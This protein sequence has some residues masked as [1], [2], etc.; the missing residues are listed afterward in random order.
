MSQPQLVDGPRE[1]RLSVLLD[2]SAFQQHLL[3]SSLMLMLD[4][5]MIVA[6]LKRESGTIT[7]TQYLVTR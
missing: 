3:G 1:K 5:L 6:Y 2:L 7:L 4:E